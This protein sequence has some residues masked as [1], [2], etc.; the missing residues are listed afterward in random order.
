M[1]DHKVIKI[2][3]PIIKYIPL[4][5]KYK[6]VWVERSIDEI[7]AS[8]EKMLDRMQKEK[9]GLNDLKLNLE[10]SSQ[11]SLSWLENRQNVSLLKIKHAE[12]IKNPKLSLIKLNAFF[13]NT[14]LVN[15]MADCVNPQ[16]YR[17]KHHSKIILDNV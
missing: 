4:N 12:I 17:E 14:L 6:V 7:A 5:Y 8:Q 1:A 2:V 13:D 3:A 16:L 10:N 9:T 11:S 15:K